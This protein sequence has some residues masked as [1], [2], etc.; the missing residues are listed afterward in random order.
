MSK[1][2]LKANSD[3]LNR[4][5]LAQAGGG[6]VYKLI[7]AANRIKISFTYIRFIYLNEP[8]LDTHTL[9]VH[10]LADAQYGEK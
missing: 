9:N 6:R 4:L 2:S 5:V 7:T 8:Y 1:K 10:H 3:M